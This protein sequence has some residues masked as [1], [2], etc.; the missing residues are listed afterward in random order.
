EILSRLPFPA[1]VD[2]DSFERRFEGGELGEVTEREVGVRARSRRRA[3]RQAQA[4]HAKEMVGEAEP[5]ELMGD[6]LGVNGRPQLA[7]QPFEALALARRQ[8]RLELRA[9]ALEAGLEARDR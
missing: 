4:E 2:A 9:Q 8:H 7:V 6:F 5:G 1:V 3:V